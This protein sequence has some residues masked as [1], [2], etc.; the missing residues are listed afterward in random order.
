MSPARVPDT[1]PR[2]G[3]PGDWGPGD[4]GSRF[5]GLGSSARGAVTWWCEVPVR[6]RGDSHRIKA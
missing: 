1:G 4:L 2:E 6:E 5:G 3:R